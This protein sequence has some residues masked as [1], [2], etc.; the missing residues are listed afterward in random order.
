MRVLHFEYCPF[1]GV[2]LLLQDKKGSAALVRAQQPRGSG[3]MSGSET[4]VRA[5]QP[6]KCQVSKS[7]TVAGHS[8]HAYAQREVEG[9]K[10]QKE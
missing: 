3:K 9:I 1:A 7:I 4:L 2:P 5:Q 6:R 10:E 8:A